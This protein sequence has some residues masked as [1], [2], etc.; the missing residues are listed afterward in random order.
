MLQS[1][2]LH[3]PCSSY[4]LDT[5]YIVA[6]ATRESQTYSKYFPKLFNLVIVIYKD[7]YLE[8]VRQDNRQKLLV[9]VC[10]Q[11]VKL[12]NSQV[13]LYNLQLLY[14]YNT[15]INIK[16]CTSMQAIKYIYKYIYKGT[17]Y[18][19]LTIK[20]QDKVKQYLQ[21]CYISL[22]EA[23]QQLF[24]FTIYKEYPPIQ[25]LIVYLLGCYLV[26]FNK[27]ATADQLCK[28][29]EQSM[30]ILTGFF[31]Y[32]TE[33][34]NSYNLLYQDFLSYFIWEKKARAQRL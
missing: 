25:A 19:I 10:Y 29:L 5:L 27:D 15:Y 6:K 24:K 16:I 23:L 20:T 9:K 13:V 2:M 8:Y 31:Y 26:I 7:S 3:S 11:E 32:N 4:N 33:H 21:G 22:L 18:A 30:L 17:N 12:D 1:F 34:A 28:R 14:K